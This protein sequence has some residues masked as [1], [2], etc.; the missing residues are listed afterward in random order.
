MWFREGRFRGTLFT[1]TQC[2]RNPTPTLPASGEGVFSPPACGGTKGGSFSSTYGW[3]N[4]IPPAC[5]GIKGGYFIHY[6]PNPQFPCIAPL[7]L[8]VLFKHPFAGVVF[9][10]RQHA[11]HIVPNPICGES[12]HS[13]PHRLH[14]GIPATIT[15]LSRPTIEML[16]AVHLN[17]HGRATTVKVRDIRA[18]GMLPAKLDAKL[19]AAET[20]PELPFRRGH[21]PRHSP[22]VAKMLARNVLP[23]AVLTDR[24]DSAIG[25]NQVITGDPEHLVAAFTAYAD[26]GASVMSHQDA[27]DAVRLAVVGVNPVTG[28]DLLDRNKPHPNP[29][30]KRGGRT[31]LPSH[32]PP[33]YGWINDI[34][35][36]CS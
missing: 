36:A 3:T 32:S 7:L 23:L 24:L 12:Q 2:C 11:L 30:R 29:P 5:G 33:T 10:L 22:G 35:P 18:D 16:F 9:D 34:P 1:G 25:Q 31:R 4:D 15:C 13:Q 6:I 20:L 17:H 14:V 27:A 26:H 21:L 28:F 8:F 19:L